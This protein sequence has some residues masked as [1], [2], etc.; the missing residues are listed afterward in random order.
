MTRKGYSLIEM[1]F[2][3]AIM[4]I[5]SGAFSVGVN[6]YYNLKS[7][8]E[9]KNFDYSILNMFNYA[10]LYCKNKECGGQIDII[11]GKD[12]IAFYKVVDINSTARV[13]KS[14][15]QLPQGFRITQN[16]V[17]NNQ[18]ISIDR[19]GQVNNACTIQYIDRSGKTH[20]ITIGVGSFY[21]DIK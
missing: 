20:T 17:P 1:L 21:V 12:N 3:M 7:E 19:Y 16:D 10:R 9:A 13:Q 14:R 18:I 8:L 5:L 15:I 11:V 4:L 2:V 6:N